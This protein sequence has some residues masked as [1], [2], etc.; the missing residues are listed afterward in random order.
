MIVPQYWAEARM[1]GRLAGGRGQRARTV[2]VRRHGWSDA[3]QA[4]AEAHAEERAREAFDRIASG[5]EPDLLRLEPR[6]AYNGADGVPIREEIVARHGE[7]I[8]T[9]NAYGSL[10]LNTPD[11]F[12]A[13]IDLDPISHG[14]AACFT[15]LLGVVAALGLALSGRSLMQALV[16]LAASLAFGTL[17]AWVVTRVY[18]VATGG[19]EAR[20]RRRIGAFLD[21]HP[22]WHVRLYRTPAG[23]RL[24]AMHRTFDPADPETLDAFRALGTDPIYVRMCVHQR[25]FRARVSPKPWRVGFDAHIPRGWPPS[26]ETLAAR[27][28]WIA[29]YGHAAAGHAACWFLEAFGSPTIHPSAR[30]VQTLHDDLSH[31]SELDWP[32]A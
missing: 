3:S 22:D 26:A 4:D 14:L 24:L 8:L 23:F 25:C 1:Q 10:C 2:T 30:A 6:R 16:V 31:A 17:A 19:P 11:V 13:D 12:F 29:E 18:D 20:A 15:T 32:L 5:E 27:D 7:T 28:R 21:A 9:R